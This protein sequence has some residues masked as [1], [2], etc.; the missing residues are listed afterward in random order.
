MGR[1]ESNV[2]VG[3]ISNM[4]MGD[5]SMESNSMKESIV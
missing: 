1:E 5:D 3:N 2:S 4:S